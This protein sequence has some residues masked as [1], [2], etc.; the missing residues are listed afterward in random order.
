[1]GKRYFQILKI[2]AV[3]ACSNL[4]KSISEFE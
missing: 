1:M 3:F 4:V 2:A